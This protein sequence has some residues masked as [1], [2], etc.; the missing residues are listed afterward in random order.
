MRFGSVL[1]VLLFLAACGTNPPVIIYKD[2][3]V[4]A[5][6]SCIDEVPVKPIYETTNLNKDSTMG[7]VT[8]AY[9]VTINQMSGYIVLLESAVAICDTK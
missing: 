8:N 5:F 3:L 7:E 4:P 9:L 1:L 2:K 6:I